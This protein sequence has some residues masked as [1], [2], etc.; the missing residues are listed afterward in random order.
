MKG[1]GQ[2]CDKMDEVEFGYLRRVLRVRKSD[3]FT[4]AD[5]LS[6]EDL[7]AIILQFDHLTVQIVAK[8][9]DDT[10]E[11][12]FD[13]A[14]PWRDPARHVLSDSAP[15]RSV[16]GM[17]LIGAWAMTNDRGYS[18]ALQLEFAEQERSVA[19]DVRIQ[20]EAAASMFRFYRVID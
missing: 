20:L 15:W 19:T 7:E 16:V 5:L 14:T 13:Q 8:G 6:S 18:D 11:L 4:G 9:L 10:V 1:F 2:L 3:E 12:H 17:R